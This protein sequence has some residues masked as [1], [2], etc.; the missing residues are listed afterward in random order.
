[1]DEANYEAHAFGTGSRVLGDNPDWELA[2]VDRGV[3]MVERDKNHASAAIWSLGN[4]GGAGRN[5]AA[6]REAVQ[7]VDASGTS[8]GDALRATA[9]FESGEVSEFIT[10]FRGAL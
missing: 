4:E 1:M 3:S 6:M 5:L 8:A 2:H 7:S 10:A 9:R